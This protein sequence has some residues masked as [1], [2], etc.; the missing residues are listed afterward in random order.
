[1]NF[2]KCMQSYDNHH[3]QDI[4][5]H[6]FPLLPQMPHVP[7]QLISPFP[8]VV[9]ANVRMLCDIKKH[10]LENTYK[11]MEKGIT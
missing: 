1:M 5:K 10:V 4:L 2:D 9:D 6:I 7:L 8:Q 11:K 3:N